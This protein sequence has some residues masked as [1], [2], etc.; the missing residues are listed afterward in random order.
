MQ[1]CDSPSRR[2]RNKN[3]LRCGGGG[4]SGRGEGGGRKGAGESGERRAASARLSATPAVGALADA[5]ISM[6]E[7]DSD[8][9]AVSAIS[10]TE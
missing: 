2:R 1:H 4:L 6:A 8:S 10:A 7:G 5:R 9:L 3:H